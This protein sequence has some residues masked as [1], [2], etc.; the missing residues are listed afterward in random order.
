MTQ[1]AREDF[2]FSITVHTDDLA[3]LQCLRALCHYCESSSH[4][5]TGTAAAKQA[6]WDGHGHRVTF[7]FSTHGCRAMFV[8]QIERLLPR[9][10][11]KIAAQ[12]D[13]DPAPVAAR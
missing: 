7:R 11:W 12:N 4:K 8:D 3:L 10:M 6:D 5:A 9:E 2:R 13:H 1:H